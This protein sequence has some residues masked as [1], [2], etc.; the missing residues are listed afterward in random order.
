MCLP[1]PGLPRPASSSPQVAAALGFGSDEFRKE[2]AAPEAGPRPGPMHYDPACRRACRGPYR[3]EFDCMPFS[4][5]CIFE[6]SARIIYTCCFGPGTSF[7]WVPPGL[8]SF[9]Q[10]TL[11][12]A[13]RILRTRTPFAAFLSTLLHLTPSGCDAP[14]GTFFPLPMPYFGLFKPCSR[15]GS[16]ARRRLGCRRCAFVSVAALNYLHAGGSPVPRAALTRR[17][18]PVHARTPCSPERCATSRALSERP[19]PRR[20]TINCK[21]DP[22][23][24]RAFI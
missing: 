19:E 7:E 2:P 8:L 16:R 24:R 13:F 9:R 4:P 1:P 15:L 23:L 6:P 17:P 3:A 20:L 10:W 11:S 22:A 12:F 14:V 21:V 18:N 5:Y